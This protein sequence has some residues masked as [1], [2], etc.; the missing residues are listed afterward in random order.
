MITI[1]TTPKPFEGKNKI[2]QHNAINSWRTLSGNIQI[3]I[4][5][6]SSGGKDMAAEVN[7]IHIP[8]IKS[9]HLNTPYIADMLAKVEDVSKDNVLC[10]INADI[11][12]PDNFLQIV[13]RASDRFRKFLMV[14]TRWDLDWSDK[15]DFMSRDSR[16]EFWKLARKNG[17][18]HSVSGMDYFVYPRGIWKNI[19]DLLAGRAGF[20]NWLIWKARRALVPVIDAST[21]IFAVHQ[22]HDYSHHPNGRMGVYEGEE[23][24]HNRK[25]LGGENYH[26][27]NILDATYKFMVGEIVL[28]KEKEEIQ[29]YRNRLS[30]VFPEFSI[31][32]QLINRLFSAF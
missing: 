26:G 12:L 6:N 10:Y 31:P 16:N 13:E 8:E 11:I 23:A 5:G 4:F 14:G 18:R 19:P 9:N 30:R 24:A 17:I 25:Y 28:K 3:V 32:M 1:F 20:D 21:E 29:R 22:S 15:I 7:A 2:I 27:L